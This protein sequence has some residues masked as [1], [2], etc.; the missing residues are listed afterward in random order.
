VPEYAV[1]VKAGILE[2]TDGTMIDYGK[3]EADIRGWCRQFNVAALR[4]DQ[5]GSAGI[6]SN[7]AADGFPAA[8]LDKNRKSMTPPARELETRIKHRRLRHDGNSCLKWMA[9]NAV[10]T[11]GVDDSILPK[12]EGP[13]SPNKIDGIDAMLQAMSAMLQ[14]PPT[15]PTPQ[16]FVYRG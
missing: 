11:R 6:V 12:K 14:Q 9:S 15:A 16:V 3:I 1:W 13:E 4:F 8:I 5:Y 7:L 10:V 2:L